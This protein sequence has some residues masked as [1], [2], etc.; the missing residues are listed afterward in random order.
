MTPNKI[1]GTIL[2]AISILSLI[3]SYK[4]VSAKDEIRTLRAREAQWQRL[5]SL[6]DS[7][8]TE[9]SK[10]LA[11]ASQTLDACGRFDILGIENGS[12]SLITITNGIDSKITERNSI[13]KAIR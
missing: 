5:K 11:T 13:M 4:L 9:S 10:G 12:V 7:I 3:V 6:D 1:I 2:V 8:I